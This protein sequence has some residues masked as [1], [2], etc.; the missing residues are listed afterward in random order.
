[1]KR[2]GIGWISSDTAEFRHS[3]NTRRDHSPRLQ[4]EGLA[5]E[6]LAGMAKS[7]WGIAAA[8]L[9]VILCLAP[10]AKAQDSPQEAITKFADAANFQNNDAYDLA[11]EEW[12]NFLAKFPKDPLSPKA[13]HYQG[14][15]YLQL[16]KYDKA[17]LAFA[18]V[19]KSHPKFEFID[20]AYINLGW[21]RYSIAQA[22]QDPKAFQAAA[23]TFAE[24]L[25]KQPDSKHAAQ[26]LFFQGESLYLAG[27]LKACLQPYQTLLQKHKESEL[28]CD[29]AYALGVAHEELK[30]YGQALKYYDQF[31]GQ[32]KQDDLANEVLMRK[33]EMVL[34]GGDTKTAETLFAQVAAIADFESADHA[35]FRQGYCLSQQNK[36]KE[37]GDLYAS[38]VGRF[39]DSSYKSDATVSAG[40]AYYR[41]GADEPAQQWF[42]KVVD[43]G[44]ADVVESAHW[45]CRLHLRNNR[46][47]LAIALADTVL[48]KAGDDKFTA[49]L[50]MD[51][52][53]AL[54][55]DPA[56]KAESQAIYISIA[57]KYP[58]HSAAS[59]ALYN[60]AFGAMEIKDHAQAIQLATQF[61][62]KFGE[63]RLV[64]DTRYVRAESNLQLRKYPEAEKELRELVALAADHP[65]KES[66]R[67]R[68]GASLYLQKKYADAEQQ[69]SKD[70]AT[71]KAP[72]QRAEAL[73]VIGACCFYQE[74]YPAA[75]KALADSGKAEPKWRQA[76]E[77]LI[78]AA[79]SQGKLGE[80]KAAQAL[81]KRVLDE[82][83]NSPVK[84]QAHYRLGEFHYA[85]GNFPEAIKHYGQV[86]TVNPDSLFAPFALYGLGWSQLK[87]GAFPQ[88]T[89]AFTDLLAKFGEHELAADTRFARAMSRRQQNEFKGVLEDV[90]AFLQS[91][92]PI[93]TRCDA[94]YERGLAEV[95]LQDFKGAVK[96]FASILKDN[97]KY[98][99]A[100]KVL[101]ELAWAH[102]SSGNA[103]A[104]AAQFAALGAAHPNSELA[105]EALFHV[106]EDHYQKKAYAEAAA[107]Y[108]QVKK[109]TK[110][111][112]LHEKSVYKLGWANYQQEKYS[113]A[114]VEFTEQAERHPQGALLSDALFM[115]GECSFKLKDY[116]AASA[117]FKAT[118]KHKPSSE[119]IAVLTLLHAG[120]SANQLENWDDSETVLSELISKHPKSNFI[121]E[122]HFERGRARQNLDR[123]D[124]AKADYTAS[125]DQSRG[126][127]GARAGFMLGE[128]LFIE[129]QYVLASR[130]FQRVMFGFGADKATEPVR[131]WQAK[132]GFE[133]G[134]CAEV[135][136][137]QAEGQAKTTAIAD[138]KKFYDYVV[139]SHPR[140]ELAEAAKKRLAVLVKL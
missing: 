41:A 105:P 17:A 89:K 6:G 85:G 76:D 35:Q 57:E 106:G 44:A 42:Q 72:D 83:P 125:T 131:N 54:Y 88:A 98:A 16:K 123:L 20:D 8:C 21:C 127:V 140:H 137:N 69:L 10:A 38:L 25:T 40:R 33:A 49:N 119:N 129:K 7:A 9:I 3:A 110:Q 11:L 111:D 104:A 79:R 68:L 126:E 29:A 117:A 75:I 124:D 136:I 47:A 30:Q 55:A 52:A 65:E 121:A 34:Q 74:K 100:D 60:A 58:D 80:F 45:I 48:P 66:W 114:L 32:C 135:L 28:V 116:A 128:V 53:D 122:A 14:V 132:S 78:F 63:N 81:A 43:A 97:A 84:D 51:K 23:A 82:F 15:C 4:T 71:I 115:Q 118:R 36:F 87:S 92:P 22:K 77:A 107:N 134:R 93:A 64:A 108:A 62:A 138:A 26:A 95:G 91:E 27:Q 86:A 1:M 61:L 112:V 12:T 39:P 90:A 103:K 13:Q 2:I 133:A 46:A 19:V 31:L 70:I 120:Q 56:K 113:E 130:R 139:R 18:A 109:A 102:K 96:T 73:F 99:S 67:V 37:A 101:Y 59:Q 5:G 50:M 24:L 94:L